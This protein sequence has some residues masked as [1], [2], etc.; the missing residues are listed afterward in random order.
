MK[1]L[2]VSLGG[3][4][5]LVEVALDLLYPQPH[6]LLDELASRSIAE[7]RASNDLV[8]HAQQILR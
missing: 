4:G 3:F 5:S 6:R 1:E 8:N 7:L 2:A